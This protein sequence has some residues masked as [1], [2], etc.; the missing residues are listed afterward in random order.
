MLQQQLNQLELLTNALRIHGFVLCM[1]TIQSSNSLQNRN[2]DLSEQLAHVHLSLIQLCLQHVLT[3]A[4]ISCFCY[5]DLNLTW[6]SVGVYLTPALLSCAF[7][8][9]LVLLLYLVAIRLP[10][11]CLSVW[12]THTSDRC[13]MR[14][15]CPQGCSRLN[16][17]YIY[18]S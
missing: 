5:I 7:L 2:Q 18:L 11:A 1:P 12:V 9:A 14:Y 17:F 13:L 4:S 3:S 10:A 6:C 15:I 8:E 16:L